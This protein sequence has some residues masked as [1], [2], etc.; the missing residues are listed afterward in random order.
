[1]PRLLQLVERGLQLFAGHTL[2]V[3]VEALEKGLVDQP[4]D[5]VGGGAVE[6]LRV[7]DKVKCLEEDLTPDGQLLTGVGEPVLDARA[8][9][10]ELVESG[11]DLRLG[12]GAVRGQ[13]E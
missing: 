2:V 8:L 10:A 6:R 5:V 7:G 1:M 12:E 11:T 9:Q 3:D 4:A 13:V